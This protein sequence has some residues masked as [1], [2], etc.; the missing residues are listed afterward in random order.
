MSGEISIEV[1]AGFS[2]GISAIRLTELSPT[3]SVPPPAT[4]QPTSPQPTDP[5]PTSP[6]PTIAP[7]SIDAPVPQTNTTPQPPP[8]T[9]QLRIV[10]GNDNLTVQPQL[11]II[12]NITTPSSSG[13]AVLT[14]GNNPGQNAVAPAFNTQPVWAQGAQVALSGNATNTDINFALTLGTSGTT[15]VLYL[16][17]TYGPATPFA[18]PL[19]LGQNPGGALTNYTA[20]QTVTAPFLDNVSVNATGSNS[21]TVTLTVDPSYVAPDNLLFTVNGSVIQL[22]GS[23]F[24]AKGLN[25]SPTPIGGATF[26]PGIGDWFTPPWW[27]GS[28]SGMG[29]RDLPN[30]ANMGVNT[31]RTYFTWFWVKDPDLNFLNSVNQSTAPLIYYPTATPTPNNYP[32]V[33]SFN[34]RP[35]LDACAAAGVRVILGIAFEGGNSFNFADPSV[36][37]AYQNFY[38]QTAIKLA[39]LYGNHPAVMGFCFGNEQNGTA[40]TNDNKATNPNNDSRVWVYYDSVRQAVKAVAPNKLFIIAFQDDQ[41]LYNG[42]QTVVDPPGTSPPSQF[43]GQ[44]IEQVISSIVDA[45]GLN[46]YSGISTD[47]PIFRANVI[48]A[49]NGAYKRPLLV[50]EWGTPSGENVPAGAA[51]PPD[52]TA[53]AQ[54]L[55]PAQFTTAG[56]TIQN[57]ITN[58]QANLDFVMGAFYFEYSDEWWKNSATPVTTQDASANPDWPEEYWG[59]FRIALTNNRP[60]ANP[61]PNQPDTLTATPFVEDVTTGY[62]SLQSAFTRFQQQVARFGLTSRAGAELLSRQN[63]L[64]PT[65]WGSAYP[66][67][68]DRQI[69]Y[70]DPYGPIRFL[71]LVEE[72]GLLVEWGGQKLFLSLR[73][74][75]HAYLQGRGWLI[76]GDGEGMGNPSL[77]LD[78]TPPDK[79]ELSTP[80]GPTPQGP[81]AAVPPL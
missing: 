4:P 74:P 60:A 29:A 79:T 68:P 55:T 39:T 12:P 47:F 30:F 46:I 65:P 76:V 27:T 31:L 73:N 53:T 59:L 77:Y 11:A 5:Q 44:P 78:L 34:H 51:G 64:E 19:T 40:N 21:Y 62:A 80:Q 35:F 48:N 7:A 50:T 42:T 13:S 54:P 33:V 45:W 22:N 8:T 43:N 63:P 56:F 6:Q 25:Y 57:A 49:A 36:S 81:S 67:D 75:D 2:V 1:I 32:Y 26:N 18:F 10:N 61:D 17:G 9:V 3:P 28:T 24:L 52:G 14:V 38:K 71:D 58:M 69:Y 66:I 15:A 70:L 16:Q 41:S 37:N 72:E 20:P 23:P